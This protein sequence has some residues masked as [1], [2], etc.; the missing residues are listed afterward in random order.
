MK[1]SVLIII[2]T[3]FVMNT[4]AQT[5]PGGV[6]SNDGS[7]ALKMWFRTDNGVVGT[8]NVSAW[9]N[10]AGVAAHNLTSSG[11]GRPSLNSG[12]ANGYDFLNFDGNDFFGITGALTVANFVTDQASTFIVN[13]RGASSSSWV[14]ATHPHQIQRFSCHVAWNNSKVYYDIGSCCASTARLQTGALSNLNNYSIWSYDALNSS[15][16]QLY[17]DGAL[18]QNR[19]N[20]LTYSSHA[21][22]TF[23]IGEAYKGQ[24]TEVIIFNQKINTAQRY[25]IEN[26]LSGKYNIPLTANNIYT[27]DDVANGDF[28]H[29]IA[30]IGRVDASN[31]HNN[32]QGTGMVR[33]L[34]PT[35]LGDDEF[36]M[37]GHDNGVAEATNII[38]VPLGVI[39]RFDRVWR[40]SEVNLSGASVSVGDIDMQWDLS[41]LN[42]VTPSDLRLLIDTDDDGL[43]ADETPIA[44]AVSLGGNIYG[45]IKVPGGA[46]GISDNRR[47]TL[48][49]VDKIQTPLPVE[50]ISFE[51]NANENRVDLEW[52]TASEINNDF[53][54]IERSSDAINWEDVSKINGAGNSNQTISYYDVDYNPIVGTSYYRLKQTDFNGEYKY[55]NIVPVKFIKG[56]SENQLINIFPNPANSGSIVELKFENITEDEILVVLRDIKGREF[57]SKIHIDIVD[58]KLIGIP[59]DDNVPKGIYLIT[60][61]SE[62]QI[63]S[64]KLIVK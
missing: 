2:T 58:G 32:A 14:Y 41:G 54:T 17:R 8:T 4:F 35:N 34:N 55:S 19:A 47:F 48:A 64:Q 22:H 26:Y 56:T 16:K 30:G 25:V 51:A 57:Y 43:F 21:S 38:D 12:G 45:F 31:I 46:L 20:T 11:T 27:Q 1:K 53:F 29:D 28:D 36:L 40:V 42:A 62:N 18:L 7:S 15:G 61:T 9:S 60:A 49:T 63:Y 5:G 3:L 23:R 52:I 10:S 59:I 6:G 50:L 33:V 44:G 13:K 39:A 37:W 24:I